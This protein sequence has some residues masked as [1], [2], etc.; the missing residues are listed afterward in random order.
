MKEK[1]DY[2]RKLRGLWAL[3]DTE[4]QKLIFERHDP[5]FID[6]NLTIP[7]GGETPTPSGDSAD[8]PTFS[9][10]TGVPLPPTIAPAT[11]DP[12]TIAPSGLEIPTNSTSSPTQTSVV[13]GETTPP[14]DAPVG[15]GTAPPTPESG[16]TIA[17]FL[18]R[19]LTDDGSLEMPGTPQNQA[20]QALE[21]NFPGLALPGDQGEITQ[22]YALNTLFY[23][24]N[25]TN[26]RIQESWT[27]PTPVC[28]EMGI[29]NEWF[30]VFCNEAGQVT[31]I[32]L[33]GNDLFG[34][35]PSEIRGLPSLRESPGITESVVFETFILHTYFLL[36]TETLIV[37]ENDLMGG[38]PDTIGELTNLVSL[39]YTNNFL[40]GTLPTSLGSLTSLMDL[41]ASLNMQNGTI[42]TQ[43]GNLTSIINIFLDSN[44]L[45]GPIPTEIGNL[46][47]LCKRNS[48]VELC[49]RCRME[50]F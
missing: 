2:Y 43:I 24:T 23:S 25:G 34:D 8:P 6:F 30:G 9:P 32:M 15:E 39:D 21:S 49:S 10:S 50:L 1:I 26:W 29:T 5:P 46:V 19:T 27:G 13:P 41:S 33:N 11:I 14:T 44:N 7:P 22:I 45:V 16:E 3:T 37:P 12:A 17:M 47:T 35:I 20:L 31:D 36:F 4:V 42:P 38:L 48:L 40:S 18:T 28:G